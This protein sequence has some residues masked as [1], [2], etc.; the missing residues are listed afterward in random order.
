MKWWLLAAA[1]AC[2]GCSK[3]KREEERR[4]EDH[5]IESEVNRAL[6]DVKQI[7]RLKIRIVC[8]EGKV[9]LTGKVKDDAAAWAAV[10]AVKEVDGVKDVVD[11]MEREGD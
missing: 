11:N 5:V 7:D 1:L 6:T 4:V 10:K 3:E 9:T 8:K 2:A